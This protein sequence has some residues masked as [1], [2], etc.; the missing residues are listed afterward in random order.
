M[1]RKAYVEALK[2]ERRSLEER[3]VDKSRLAAVDAELER[4]SGAPKRRQRETAVPKDTR[5][6]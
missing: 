6:G 5:E 1:D 3:G 2:V 4:F